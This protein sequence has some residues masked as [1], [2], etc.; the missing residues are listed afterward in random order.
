MSQTTD[1][2][3][4]SARFAILPADVGVAILVGDLLVGEGGICRYVN[5]ANL[6]KLI[7]P[8]RGHERL[9]LVLGTGSLGS[10]V[11]GIGG[12]SKVDA[13][14]VLRKGPLSA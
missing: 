14:V 5:G 10:L 12:D 2:A 3:Y 7:R 8:G 11:V 13:G 1:F 9:P 6:C 4:G